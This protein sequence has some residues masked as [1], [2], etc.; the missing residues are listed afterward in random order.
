MAVSGLNTIAVNLEKLKQ[1]FGAKAT[2]KIQNEAAKLIIDSAKAKVDVSTKPH[3]RKDKSGKVIATYYPGNL[4]RSIGLVTFKKS[5]TG[6]T[7]VGPRL[8]KSGSS[9]DFKGNRIDGYYGHFVEYNVGWGRKTG[10]YMRP[11]YDETKETVK[12]KLEQ[13]MQSLF[14]GFTPKK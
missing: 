2:K 14:N 5:K 4:K 13:G 12:K 11:A 6:F 8:Y 9:G 10:P 7:F 3:Q 1:Q